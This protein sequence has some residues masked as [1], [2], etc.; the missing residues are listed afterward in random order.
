MADVVAV[1]F[2]D[3]HCHFYSDTAEGVAPKCI[4]NDFYE[5]ARLSIGEAQYGSASD[6]PAH[7]AEWSRKWTPAKYVSSARI[8]A[9]VSITSTLAI[10]CR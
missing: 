2:G 8:N 7:D 3:G 10:I 4:L 5:S 9:L 1:S 6:A